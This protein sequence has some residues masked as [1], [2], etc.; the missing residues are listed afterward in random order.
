MR[1]KKR[2]LCC[3]GRSQTFSFGGP[4]EGPVLQ[5]GELSMVCVGL[6]C[7]DMTSR[8]KFLGGHWGARQNFGGQWPPL[9][10]PSS[11]PIYCSVSSLRILDCDLTNDSSPIANV[12]LHFPHPEPEDAIF[13]VQRCVLVQYIYS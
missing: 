13:I 12:A 7:S 9:A 3:Q 11:A 2:F 5:Q 8:G 1:I 6:K 10:P 4:L